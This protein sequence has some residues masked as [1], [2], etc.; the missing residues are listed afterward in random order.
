M[1]GCTDVGPDIHAEIMCKGLIAGELFWSS[2]FLE[3]VHLFILTKDDIEFLQSRNLKP[4]TAESHH[5]QSQAWIVFE[6]ILCF[7]LLIEN[8]CCPEAVTVVHLKY[9]YTVN[10]RPSPF[11]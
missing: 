7:L 4:V 10:I 2:W 1:Y 3:F 5:A 9:Y 11:Q 6:V 8:N